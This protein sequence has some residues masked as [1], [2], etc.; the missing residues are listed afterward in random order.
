MKKEEI[1][2]EVGKPILRP[3]GFAHLLFVLAFFISPFLWIWFDFDVAWKTMLTGLIGTIVIYWF[4]RIAKKTVVETVES[5]MKDMKQS[6]ENYIPKRSRFQER[7]EQMQKQGDESK[8][9]L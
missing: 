3:L 1:I 6:H 5:E 9:N 2:L 8:N 4:Y 7:L